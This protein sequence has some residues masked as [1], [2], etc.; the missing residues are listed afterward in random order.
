MAETEA[1]ELLGG[2]VDGG[3]GLGEEVDQLDARAASPTP[4]LLLVGVDVEVVEVV[5]VDDARRPTQN[6]SRS[7]GS[8]GW[9]ITGIV[10]P[11]IRSSAARSS[12]AGRLDQPVTWTGMVDQRFDHID[13]GNR[14]PTGAA[15]VLARGR[16]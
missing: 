1:V 12:G 14:S 5:A 2:G 11:G 10:E 9:R 4:V 7:P 13:S 3:Q 8:N 15:G 6:G 16:R